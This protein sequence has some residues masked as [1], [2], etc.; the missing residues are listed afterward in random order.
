MREL[1]ASLAGRGV[2]V[3]MSSHVLTEV[4]RMATR[5]GVVH[6]GRLVA[7]LSAAE[8]ATRRRLEVGARDLAAAAAI[9]RRAGYEPIRPPD[10][11][12]HVLY[13]HDPRAIDGPDEIARRLVAGGA[14]PTRL[15]A[16]RE[17]MESLFLSL[18]GDAGPVED[19]PDT[20][21]TGEAGSLESGGDAAAGVET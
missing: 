2:T 20:A 19:G 7:E 13:L 17:D 18:T 10:P 15:V 6:R 9:L 12:D 8:L 4:E 21:G 11:A 14:P 3:F 16:V 1:L 5:V